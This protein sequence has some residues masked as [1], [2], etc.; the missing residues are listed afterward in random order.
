VIE[1]R[2]VEAGAYHILSDRI[3]YLPRR[4]AYSRRNPMAD[5]VREITIRIDTG[6]VLRLLTND[7]DAPA[8]AIAALYKRR[9]QIELFSRWIKQVLKIRHFFSVSA[10]A[11]TTQVATALITYLLL[12]AAHKCYGGPLRPLDFVR[13]VRINLMLEC[14]LEALLPP[15]V[16]QGRPV[17]VKHE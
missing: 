9:W 2:P 3:G 15:V 4:Q 1:T 10:N 12:H 6:A 7:L 5:A 17:E 13:L 8:S 16:P 11:V 14:P